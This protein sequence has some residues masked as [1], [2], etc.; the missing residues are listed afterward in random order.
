MCIHE[1]IK[2]KLGDG[3]HTLYGSQ[4][5]SFDDDPFFFIC[6]AL[7]SSDVRISKLLCLKQFNSINVSACFQ[8][9]Q[10]HDKDRNV[11]KRSSH[12]LPIGLEM[13]SSFFTTAPFFFRISFSTTEKLN[14][15]TNKPFY[16]MVAIRMI[17]ITLY[18]KIKQRQHYKIFFS[19]YLTSHIKKT[20]I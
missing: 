4:S 1:F 10:H 15:K 3:W 16:K 19:T 9:T 6:S 14:K 5:T 12:P 13:I 20:F 2:D 18:Y 17:F 7:L 8:R 11:N